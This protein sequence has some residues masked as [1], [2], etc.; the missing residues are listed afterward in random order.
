MTRCILFR[1]A[2]GRY[3][4]FEVKGHSGYAEAGSDI[5]CAA[6]SILTTTCVNAMESVA[7]GGAQPS[8]GEGGGVG[9]KP[10][11]RPPARKASHF[12]GGPAGRRGGVDQPW[13]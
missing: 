10:P 8:G 3:T 9:G 13:R 12:L 2:E 11:P 4:G 5:V 1:D 7:G 6:V